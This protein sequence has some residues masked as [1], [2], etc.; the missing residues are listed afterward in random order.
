MSTYARKQKC[1]VRHLLNALLTT[2][3]IAH[4]SCNVILY[5]YFFS[6]CG[7]GTKGLR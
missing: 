5:T 7:E 3:V 1:T 4:I 6:W 2:I